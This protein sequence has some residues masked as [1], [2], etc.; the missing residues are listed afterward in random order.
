MVTRF[1]NNHD[2]SYLCDI[3]DPESFFKGLNLITYELWFELPRSLFVHQKTYVQRK[4]SDM[5]LY[6]ISSQTFGFRNAI[7]SR[8]HNVCT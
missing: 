7:P 2:N 6:L 8:H 5:L 3:R 4:K 1:V